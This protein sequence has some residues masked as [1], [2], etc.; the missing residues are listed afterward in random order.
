MADGSFRVIVPTN[1]ALFSENA[2]LA[3]FSANLLD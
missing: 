1:P 3:E 2:G